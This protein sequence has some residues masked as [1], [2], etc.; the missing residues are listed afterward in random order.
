MRNLIANFIVK[1]LKKLDIMLLTRE[2]AIGLSSDAAEAK[3]RVINLTHCLEDPVE[4]KIRLEP[5]AYL[6]TQPY[7]A[8]A[9]WDLYSR[10]DVWARP[11]EATCVSPGVYIDI[12]IGYEGE[13]K[14]RSSFGKMGLSLHHGT[15]DVGYQG[16][17]APYIHNWLN[18]RYEIH[19]G[20]RV[21]Q[22]CLRKKIPIVW[23]RV[24]G[25]VPSERGDKG[26]GSSG[27]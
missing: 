25:F 7:E 9:C 11:G 12:P 17:I 10:Y 24:E 18:A 26:H 4:L 13:L 16:E 27:R 23:S 14:A 8:D 2:D 20:D 5:D 21:A 6:P 3:T 1:Q 19:K 22:F 15:I